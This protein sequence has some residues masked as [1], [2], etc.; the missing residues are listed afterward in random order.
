MLLRNKAEGSLIDSKLMHDKARS[1]KIFNNRNDVILNRTRILLDERQKPVSSS[2]FWSGLSPWDLF[3]QR[4]TRNHHGAKKRRYL[5]DMANLWWKRM[6]RERGA[7]QSLMGWRM[8]LCHVETVLVFT[9]SDFFS[10][11]FFS[12]QMISL[13]SRRQDI[14]AQ[15][16]V[17]SYYRTYGRDLSC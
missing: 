17:P 3:R 11:A 9:V 14:E 5:T 7:Q 12:S 10:F 15:L 1:K 2:N 13:W 6:E 16:S 4:Q 8:R